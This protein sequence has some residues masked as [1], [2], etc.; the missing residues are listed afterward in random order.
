MKTA[1]RA[2]ELTA[3]TAWDVL[4]HFGLIA[5]ELPTWLLAR[6]RFQLKR[7]LIHVGDPRVAP[8]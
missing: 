2:G 6:S 4:E 8:P 1:R 3:E 7:Q 5:I